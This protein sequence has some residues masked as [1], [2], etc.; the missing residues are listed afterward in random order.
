MPANAIFAAAFATLALGVSAPA[1]AAPTTDAISATTAKTQ[2]ADN[3]DQRYCI[4]TDV[5]G[6]RLLRREC[7]KL[8]EWQARGIDPRLLPRRR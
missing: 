2:R 8:G 6:S 7:D 3:P 5:T 4:V 1:L